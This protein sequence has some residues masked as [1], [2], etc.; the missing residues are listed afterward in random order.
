MLI[1]SRVSVG[2]ETCLSRRARAGDGR[3]GRSIEGL[4]IAKNS[5]EIWKMVDMAGVFSKSVFFRAR[6]GDG[7]TGRSIEGL[8]VAKNRREIWKMVGPA[9]LEP[10]TGRL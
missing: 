2:R 1:P 4:S 9:G 6:A 7:R 10:A 5:R 8:S 3:T